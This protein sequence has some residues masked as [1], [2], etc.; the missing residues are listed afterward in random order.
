MRYVVLFVC[1]GTYC[2][3]PLA[4]SEAKHSGSIAPRQETTKGSPQTSQSELL[5][6]R[7]RAAWAAFKMR[8][9]EKYA[10]FLAD[11]F[12]AV[13]ADGDGERS[14]ARILLEVQHSMYTDYL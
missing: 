12:Q 6:S 3:A 4:G 10:E 9:Q 5:E 7:V 14:K 1:L 11:D 2:F 8:D 13:E